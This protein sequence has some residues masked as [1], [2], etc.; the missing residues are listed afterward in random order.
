MIAIALMSG[1]LFA[2][3]RMYA[4]AVAWHC[5]HGNY[6]EVGGHKVKLSILWW[7]ERAHAHETSDMRDH[8]EWLARACPSNK[9]DEKPEIDVSPAIPGEVENTQLEE[10]KL[11][12]SV[13]STLSHNSAKGWSHSLVTLTPRPFTVY[14]IRDDLTIFGDDVLSRLTCYTAKL[15]YRFIYDGPP[16]REKEAESILSSLE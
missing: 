15:P 11:T 14:C 13:I 12:Q 8:D 9:L 10:L 5:V 6:A 1:L 16:T 4:Y 2:K 3:Y 7:K